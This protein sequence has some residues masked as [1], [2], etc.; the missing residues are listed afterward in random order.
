M[1]AVSIPFQ[2]WI[3]LTSWGV[4]A[5]DPSL[6]FAPT[7]FSAKRQVCKPIPNTMGLCHDV[8]YREMR[9]PNL[10][11]HETIKEA[12]QQAGS[13]VPLL[14]KQCHRDT[15]K[16]LCSLFAPV[17]LRELEQPVRPCRSL[18]EGVRD[19][20]LPVMSAFG[21]PWPEI[22]NCSQFPT[23]AEVCIPPTASPSSDN[24]NAGQHNN[25]MDGT[26]ICEACSLPEGG[27]EIL[28]NYCKSDFVVRLRVK[29][30]LL[31]GADRKIV[32]NGKSRVVLRQGDRAEEE[33]MARSAL[34]LPEGSRCACEELDGPSSGIILALGS[35]QRGRLV[36]SKLLL[37]QRSDK[38]LRK[39]LRGLQ[40]L[41]C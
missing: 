6:Q 32:P 30:T 40:K 20:C 14:S 10:L 15:K 11:G 26:L 18:C 19:G 4:S 17:C 1:M 34:W 29:E 8:G 36:L 13:W 39:F 22:L 38:E 33:S 35:R 12:Q 31:L 21:F 24:G 9:L 7:G 3:L 23:G 2:V 41:R 28:E 27:K 37:W 5:A 16:F 25:D